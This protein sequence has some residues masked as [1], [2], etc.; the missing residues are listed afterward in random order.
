MSRPL[1]PKLMILVGF[2]A[3]IIC[4]RLWKTRWRLFGAGALLWNLFGILK[5]S[6]QESKAFSMAFVYRTS[7]RKND[8]KAAV[9]KTRLNS[10]NSPISQIAHFKDSV[11]GGACS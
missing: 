2:G 10:A 5:T 4:H 7:Y 8:I 1:A 3:V 9:K 11:R 6:C